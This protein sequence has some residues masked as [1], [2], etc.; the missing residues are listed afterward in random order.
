MTTGD[1][2]VAENVSPAWLWFELSVW[3]RRTRSAVPAGITNERG[4]GGGVASTLAWLAEVAG[5]AV[6]LCGAVAGPD[7]AEPAAG[8]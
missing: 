2:T 7:V 5:Y 3:S 1:S 6:P 4:A 8:S